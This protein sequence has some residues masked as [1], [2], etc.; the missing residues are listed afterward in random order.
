MFNKQNILKNVSKPDEKLTFSKAFDR[1]YYCIKNYEPAFTDFLDPYKIASILSLIGN[2][3]DFNI[4]VFGGTDGCE[5]QKIGFFPEFISEDDYVFPISAIEIT[6]N[7]KFSR[8][9]THRDFLGSLIGLGIVRE[10]IGD[11][12]T[13]DE[14]VFVFVD[15]DIAEFINI[16]LEKVGR[17][18]VNTRI[19]PVDSIMINDNLAEIRNIVVVSLRIDAVLSK[20]FNMP[21]GKVS[22]LIKSEKAFL[23]W[24]LCDSVSKTVSEGDIITLRGFGRVKIIELIGKTKKDRFIISLQQFR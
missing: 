17:T 10:K 4:R 5:R 15:E 14:K 12:I 2:K 9:L 13:D 7:I 21:R 24:N 11:I 3:Y 6:Y 19:I 23:N 16:N 8:S 20:V 1:A 18:K 22:E